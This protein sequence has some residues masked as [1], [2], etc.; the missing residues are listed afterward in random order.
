MPKSEEEFKEE[1]VKNNATPEEGSAE[2]EFD[3][4]FDSLVDGEEP[5]DKVEED[6]DPK[7]EEDLESS[8]EESVYKPS[9]EEEDTEV[10]DDKTEQTEEERIAELEADLASEKQRSASWDGR[11]KAAATRQKAAE[12]ELEALKSSQKDKSQSDDALPEGENELDIVKEFTDEFPALKAPIELMIKQEAKKIVKESLKDV[13]PQMQ[14]VQD[15][16]AESSN[17]AH[18]SAITNAHSDW[19]TIRDTGKLQKWIDVQPSFLQK[20]LQKVYESGDTQE[21]IEMFSAYKKANSI[22]QNRETAETKKKAEKLLAVKH[23]TGG[24]PKQKVKAAKDDFDGAWD[25]AVSA[26]K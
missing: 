6:P 1:E 4:A 10:E 7:E 12:D 22:N 17:Q 23:Q 18:L 14:Q 8:E 20:S 26:K 19:T 11:I 2:D 25:E 15:T 24:P 21:V 3:K 9:P 5:E 13:A 16:L